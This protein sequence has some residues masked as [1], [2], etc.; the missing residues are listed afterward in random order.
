[1]RATVVEE[2]NTG[3]AEKAENEDFVTAETRVLVTSRP[4]AQG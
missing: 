2:A 3:I 1:M 4:V